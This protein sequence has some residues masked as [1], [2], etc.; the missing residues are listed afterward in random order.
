MVLI[1]NA[2]H[3]VGLLL[4]A[5]VPH[6]AIGALRAR[7]LCTHAQLLMLAGMMLCPL[8]MVPF[9]LVTGF[10]INLASIPVYLV[11]SRD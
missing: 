10:F 9:M 2:T 8:V 4:G 5:L 7:M 1:G 3:S 11:C 6:P